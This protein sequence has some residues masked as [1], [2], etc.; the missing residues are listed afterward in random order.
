MTQPNR[1]S[2]EAVEELKALR[3]KEYATSEI[4]SAV[5]ASAFADALTLI[6]QLEA[7]RK[8][9]ARLLAIY[10]HAYESGSSPGVFNI[11]ATKDLLSRLKVARDG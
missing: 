2:V 8:E 3:D 4:R 9:L 10:S 1:A 5:L 11:Q 6:S 7:E